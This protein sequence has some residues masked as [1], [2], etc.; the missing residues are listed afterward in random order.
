MCFELEPNRFEF[1]FKS[2]EIHFSKS[3]NLEKMADDSGDTVRLPA[4]V[5][6]LGV[7]VYPYSPT[8]LRTA[9]RVLLPQA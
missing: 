9:A 8:L 3:Q 1:K 5:S 7:P 4:L 6:S 2:H